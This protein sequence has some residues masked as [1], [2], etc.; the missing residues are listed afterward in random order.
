MVQSSARAIYFFAKST[1]MLKMV[2]GGSQNGGPPKD[3]F[4]FISSPAKRGSILRLLGLDTLIILE[5][6]SVDLAASLNVHHPR[7]RAESKFESV[8]ILTLA[9]LSA[10]FT[11]V[12]KGCYANG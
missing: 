8:S 6:C 2:S 3:G 5:S 10:A 11:A 1:P 12:Q 9:I 4:P 7:V